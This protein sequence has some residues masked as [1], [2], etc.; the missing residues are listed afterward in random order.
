MSPTI[1]ARAAANLASMVEVASVLKAASSSS[2]ELELGAAAGRGSSRCAGLP[3][4]GG[5]GGAGSTAGPLP[6][7][8]HGSAA[9]QGSSAAEAAPGV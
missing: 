5:V 3:R 9:C 2:M 4:E 6:L 1:A 7:P 8:F